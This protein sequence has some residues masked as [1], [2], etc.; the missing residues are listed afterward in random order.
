MTSANFQ[1]KQSVDY[2]YY[3][4]STRTYIDHVFVLDLLQDNAVGCVFLPYD[5][6]NTRDYLSIKPTIKL[7][8]EQP[9]NTNEV[10]SVLSV[11]HPRLTGTS[12]IIV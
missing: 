2:T 10:D 4:G 6:E 3:K 8:T 5:V 7:Q 11:L 9:S 12:M 1:Y